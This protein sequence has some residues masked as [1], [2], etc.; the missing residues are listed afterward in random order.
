MAV[1]GTALTLAGIAAQVAADI[2][3]VALDSALPSMV[4]SNWKS[5]AHTTRGASACTRGT[6]DVPARLRGECTGTL[7]GVIRPRRGGDRELPG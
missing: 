4:E 7:S 5:I 1:T 2:T 3:G 6:E